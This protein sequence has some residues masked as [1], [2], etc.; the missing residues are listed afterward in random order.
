MR[1]RNLVLSLVAAA[2][3]PACN[4]TSRYDATAAELTRAEYPTAFYGFA[5]AWK[6]LGKGYAYALSKDERVRAQFFLDSCISELT[7]RF[8]SAPGPAVRAVQIGECMEA[9]GWHLALEE[10][11]ATP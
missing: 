5:K 1:S 4:E 2:L 6:P 8:A 3:L 9:R 10:L 11:I 7:A